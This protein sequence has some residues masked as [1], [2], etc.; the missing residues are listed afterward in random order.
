[1]RSKVLWIEDGAMFEAQDFAG[2]VYN[3]RRY[4]LVIALNI[5]DAVEEL[6]KEEFDVVIVDIRMAPGDLPQWVKLYQNA[7]RNKIHARLGL[8]LLHCLFCPND[9]DI[10]LDLIPK[11]IHPN[12]FAVFTV[13]TWQELKEHLVKCGIEEQSHRQKAAGMPVTA[14]LELIDS[15]KASLSRA[16]H[17]EG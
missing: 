16:G 13:E 17:P 11:W 12:R 8:V 14:L 15:V 6:L 5:S 4:D 10:K 1:M 3:S 7:G 2:P 9:I